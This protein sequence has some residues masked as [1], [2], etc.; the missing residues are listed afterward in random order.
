M[1]DPNRFTEFLQA[2]TAGLKKDRELQL[3]VQAE[4]QSHLEER[5]QAALATGLA[6]DAAED[7]AIRAM[8]TPAELAAE[9]QR[10]NRQRMRLRASLRLAAQWLLAPVAI[11]VAILTTEWGS[12]WVV[13]AVSRL[14]SSLVQIPEPHLLHRPLTPDQRLVLRT[15][16]HNLSQRPFPADAT[17]SRRFVRLAAQLCD[18]SGQV[19]NRDLARAAFPHAIPGG[20][21]TDVMIAIPPLSEA[22]AFQLKFDLVYEGV[23]WFEKCGSATTRVPLVVG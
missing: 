17:Y 20:G 5:Q 21:A 3:D 16:V 14:D 2:A 22:G 23:D 10:S 12:F 1:A 7:E 8:G 15:R 6:P 11:L 18:P 13:R 4:L 9:L 19:V